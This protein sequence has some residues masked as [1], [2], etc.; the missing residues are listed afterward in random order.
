MMTLR[1]VYITGYNGTLCEYEVDECLS[2]P[3]KNGGTCQDLV[4]RFECECPSGFDGPT[5]ME[6]TNECQS[7]PCRNGATCN[8]HVRTTQ[9]RN[10]YREICEFVIL[11]RGRV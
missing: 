10:F 5:C 3:C 8:D 4:G 9:K 1:Y 11:L 2:S 7:N 6:E